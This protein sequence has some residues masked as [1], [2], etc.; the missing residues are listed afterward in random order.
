MLPWLDQEENAQLGV[1]CWLSMQADC[2]HLAE[3]AVH[4]V[5]VEQAVS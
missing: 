1:C 5:H 2:Q 3:L 4:S